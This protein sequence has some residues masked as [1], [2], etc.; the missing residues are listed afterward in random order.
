MQ[1]TPNTRTPSITV[2]NT[3]VSG[4]AGIENNSNQ[5][6]LSA[7][8]NFLFDRGKHSLKFGT[9]VEFE[10][11]KS[12]S[13]DGTNGAFIFTTLTDYL[14]YRPAIYTKRLG[15]SAIQLNQAQIA[16]YAQDDIRVYQNF[17]IGLGIRYELQNNL[18]D[19]NNFSP[20]LSFTYSPSKEG[21]IVF[22]SGMGIFYQWLDTQNLVTILNN[23]GRQVS[24]LIIINPDYP[25]PISN[26]VINQPIGK[27]ILKR[28]ENLI[29]PYFFV[30]QTGFNYR[31]SKKLNLETLYRFQRGIHQFR[32]RDVNAPINNLRPNSL[33]GRITQV[34]S[35]GNLSEHSLEFRA[36]GDL[37]KGITFNSRYKFSKSVNDFDGIFNL[38]INSYDLSLERGYSSLD[39]RHRLTGSLNFTLLNKLQ[40]TSIFR[41]DSPLPYTITTGRDDNGDS[42]F[43]DRPSGVLRNTERGQWLK[44]VD[45]RLRWQVP[46]IKLGKAK[47]SVDDSKT[48]KPSDL[49]KYSM[50][51][52]ITIQ[53]IFNSTNLQNF[54]GNQLSPY[55]R[56]PISAAPARQMQFGLNFMF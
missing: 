49:K 12:L 16:F 41:L 45:L 33:F 34:E 44:Q 51:M 56:Q 43:N 39:R 18:N 52:E 14:N 7:A 11:I 28:A 53:N 10:R 1:T 38:P 36:E 25:N 15:V 13:E 47:N 50:G 54:V 31:V 22:R 4:G 21:K 46:I 40:V 27:S 26:E 42:V 48:V 5:H 24:D 30:I 19:A 32:S 6:K 55:Y 29:N 2:L 8:D 9:A 35:S 17:Q 3:F 20:R 37:P 23:D